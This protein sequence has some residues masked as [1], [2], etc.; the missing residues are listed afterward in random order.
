MTLHDAMVEALELAGQPLSPKDLAAAV[1][2]LGRYSRGDGASV[3]S[4]QV[5]ARAKRYPHLFTLGNGL[6]GLKSI[7]SVA[8]VR[9]AVRATTPVATPP[10]VSAR[11]PL[12]LDVVREPMAPIAS[13][14]FIDVGTLRELAESGLPQHEWLESCGVYAL[15]LPTLY[16]ARFVNREAALK[17]GNVLRP[18]SLAR[19]ESKWVEGTRIAYIGIA[20]SR[21]PRPLRKRLT[22]LL[23]HRAGRTSDNGPHKGGEILWQLVETDSILLRAMATPGP[24]SP[25]DVER[26]LL[27]A[28]VQMYGVLPFANR[29]G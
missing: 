17:A 11:V 8:A 6:V 4:N 26:Q 3:P 27:S 18:W 10:A 19:L 15:V 28:F 7:S 5:G 25:R 1:N 2:R 13:L 12:K 29:Q 24:P 14:P 9:P 23:N 20:G 22:D 21:S 16:E